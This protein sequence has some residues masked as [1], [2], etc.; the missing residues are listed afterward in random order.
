MIQ[1]GQIVKK[2][3]KQT[4][5]YNKI[6]PRCFFLFV[7][8][9]NKTWCVKKGLNELYFL[10]LLASFQQISRMCCALELA[11]TLAPKSVT[12]SA[13]FFNPIGRIGAARLAVSAVREI[14]GLHACVA[15]SNL[16]FV[17]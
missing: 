15:N 1:V 7:F 10:K 5:I 4:L 12:S 8:F 14:P 13:K 2:L 11:V 17:Q 3:I 6:C 9:T 16:F